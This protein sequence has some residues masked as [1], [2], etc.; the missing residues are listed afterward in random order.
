MASKRRPRKIQNREETKFDIIRICQN[1]SK[2]DV[3][4]QLLD[5]AI[6]F[7]KKDY[8]DIAEMYLDKYC[9]LV[10]STRKNVEKV[11]KKDKYE[12]EEDDDV[13]YV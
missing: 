6:K 9:F 4:D 8:Q 12:G 10:D 5:K 3:K 2:E 7:L 1:G 13:I 11:T